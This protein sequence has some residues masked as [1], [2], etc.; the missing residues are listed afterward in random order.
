MK[1]I[2]DAL[3]KDRDSEIREVVEANGTILKKKFLQMPLLHFAIITKNSEAS[4]FFIEY[5]APVG[6][7]DS[8]G[9]TALHFACMLGEHKTAKLLIQKKADINAKS[10][11][12]QTPLLL[13]SAT[14]T[15]H[16][17]TIIGYLLACPEIEVNCVDS[18]NR[19]P[20]M[21]VS[22]IVGFGVCNMSVF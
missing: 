11:K 13:A 2:V 5:G 10:D 8:I 3:I 17:E 14:Q 1:K 18:V 12:R 7:T 20:L 16:S 6:L 22:F 4:A 15:E 9:F 21:Y 19:T